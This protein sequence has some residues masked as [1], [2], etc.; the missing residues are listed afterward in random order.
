MNHSL[1]RYNRI[2][3]IIRRLIQKLLCGDGQ[4]NLAALHTSLFSQINM[5]LLDRILGRKV[6]PAYNAIIEGT[7]QDEMDRSYFKLVNLQIPQ[8]VGI[9]TEPESPVIAPRVQNGSI[10]VKRFSD[11]TT[12]NLIAQSTDFQNFRQPLTGTDRAYELDGSLAWQ[13]GINLQTDSS[14]LHTCFLLCMRDGR[15]FGHTRYQQTLP[16]KYVA[17]QLEESLEYY[18]TIFDSRFS[19]TGRRKDFPLLQELI[20]EQVLRQ[21]S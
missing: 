21:S 2:S 9:V 11:Y 18:K 15:I 14:V 10:V 7:F 12:Y 17:P 13:P 8:S 3:Q 4:G 6:Q 1:I 20:R 16:H 5:S 19:H